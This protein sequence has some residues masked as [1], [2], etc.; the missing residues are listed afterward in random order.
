MAMSYPTLPSRPTRAHFARLLWRAG[1]S[2][3]TAQITR[4]AKLG[5][6][7]AIKELLNPFTRHVLSG[8]APTDSGAPLD[9]INHWGHHCLWW[10]DRMVRSRNQLQERMTLNLHDLFATSNAGVGNTRHM[11]RQNRLLRSHAL[12]NFSDLLQRITIDPAMLLWLN[13][14]DSTSGSQTRITVAR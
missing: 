10:L 1:F 14:A 12:G 13:G 6:P 4:Y 8:P 11:L 5:L 7:A 3:S 9:P 2:G